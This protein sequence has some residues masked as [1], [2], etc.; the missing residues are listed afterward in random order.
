MSSDMSQE[1]F[2]GVR[3]SREYS[4]VIN[5]IY[6]LT[7]SW[8]TGLTNP[9]STNEESKHDSS[10]FCGRGYNTALKSLE[11]TWGMHLTHAQYI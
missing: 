6:I 8:S 5:I 4:E 1:Q 2:T 10:Y 3:L 9:V 7:W 11:H